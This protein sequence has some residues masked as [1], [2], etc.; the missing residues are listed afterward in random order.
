MKE[1]N[2]M[3]GRI[4]RTLASL[5]LGLLIGLP[6]AAGAAQRADCTT[7]SLA[8]RNTICFSQAAASPTRSN[9]VRREVSGKAG[10]FDALG[11]G[12]KCDGV[13]DDSGAFAA[14]HT[15]LPSTGGT[16]LLPSGRC[17]VKNW[18]ITKSGVIIQGAG[19]GYI[20]HVGATILQA[21]NGVRGND[22][23]IKVSGINT[24]AVTIR[25]VEFYGL[26]PNGADRVGVTVAA[27]GTRLRLERVLIHGGAIRNFDSRVDGVVAD[28]QDS[29]GIFWSAIDGAVRIAA[30]SFRVEGNYFNSCQLHIEGTAARTGTQGVT[31]ANNT[32]DSCP[33]PILAVGAVQVVRNLTIIGNRFS[34]AMS[35]AGKSVVTLGEAHGVE[36]VAFIGNQIDGGIDGNPARAVE[37]R[38]G[39]GVVIQGNYFGGAYT[40]GTGAPILLATPGGNLQIDGNV[41]GDVE[42]E[43]F[44]SRSFSL[45]GTPSNGSFNAKGI[46]L[47]TRDGRSTAIYRFKPAN[48][49]SMGF[50]AHVLGRMMDTVS[51]FESQAAFYKTLGGAL[52]QV[53]ATSNVVGI[54]SDPRTSLIFNVSNGTTVEV[55]V[56]GV[57]GATYEW[58]A[59]MEWAVR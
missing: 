43:A 20:D 55:I 24:Y 46:I 44:K 48:N 38:N 32:F 47:T 39:N 5:T 9:E 3:E 13:T 17:L 11:F 7:L 21:P 25:D 35:P 26:A 18:T 57:A 56:T 36:G 14:V 1:E 23:V 6:V 51:L 8:T 12:A 37:I 28:S 50:K 34:G 49:T 40:A 42:F 58:L 45:V 2:Q 41:G 22:G 29:G 33:A 10:Y 15:A 53:G 54:K 19:S 52:T 59:D 27:N 16:I 4:P 31:V 30:S